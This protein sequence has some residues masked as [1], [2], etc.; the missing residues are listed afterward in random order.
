MNVSALEIK[1]PKEKL[2][3]FISYMKKVFA[4]GLGGMD[5]GKRESVLCTEEITEEM[6]EKYGNKILRIA[7]SYLHNMYDAE[8]ILQD[9]LIQYIKTQPEFESSEHEKAWLFR[10]AI[11]LS[12]NKIGYKRIRNTDELGENLRQEER[13]D[14]S[15]IWEAIKSLPESQREVIHLYYEEGY[16]TEEIGNILSKNESTVRSSLRRGRARLKEILK[17]VYDFEG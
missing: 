6:L 12:K 3:A 16:S 4:S 5:F 14:L 17:E 9:T 1:A 2:G 10:V 15:F 7:Y 11:N 8:D 13:E